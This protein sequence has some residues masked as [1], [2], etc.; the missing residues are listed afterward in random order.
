MIKIS[1]DK[2]LERDIGNYII[3]LKE[4]LKIIKLRKK[5]KIRN[6]IFIED[7]LKKN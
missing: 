1:L 2:L 3:S 5:K 6:S 4:L 7:I